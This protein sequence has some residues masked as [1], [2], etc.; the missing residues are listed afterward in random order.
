MPVNVKNK[1]VIKLTYV[2]SLL[3]PILAKSLKEVN[4]IF[5]YFKKNTSSAQKKSYMQASSKIFSLNI[6]LKTL[7]IKKTFLYLQNKK[8]EQVQK[9]IS[10][11][12]K[13][14]P[15]INMTTKSLLFKQVIVPMN[16][17][18][19]K[20]YLKDSNTY[21]VSINQALKSIKSNVMA[22]FIHIDDK[23]IVISTNNV[24]NPSDLQKI[25]KYIKNSLNTDI[26]QISSSRLL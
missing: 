6:T 26:N 13:T 3:P 9:L 14:K 11:K 17:K 1:E 18:T 12:S 16:N 2:S 20:K 15:Y 7:K 24:A 4:E 25:K 8:I 5:K 21:I 10:S 19:A 22:N 23:G